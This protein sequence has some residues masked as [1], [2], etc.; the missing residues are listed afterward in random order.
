M[1]NARQLAVHALLRIQHDGAYANILTNELLKESNFESQDS[2]F[3]TDLVNGTTR[4][5]RYLDYVISCCVNRSLSEVQ[6]EVLAILQISTYSYLFRRQPEH[7]VVNEAVE[8]ARLLMGERAVGFVNGVMRKVVKTSQE[9]WNRATLNQADPDQALAIRYSMPDWIYLYFK[10][11]IS[12][13]TE[14]L[15]L[16]KTLNQAPEVSFL[17]PP[18]SKIELRDA[19]LGDWSPFAF[20]PSSKGNIRN[21]LNKSNFIV[22]DEGSQLIALASLLVPIDGP[23]KRWLDMTAGPGGK[24]TFLAAAARSRKATLVAN[25]LHQHRANLIKNNLDRLNLSAEIVVSDALKST[26]R[27]EFDRVLLDAPCTGLGALRRRAESR[28]RKQPQDL[29]QL[30]DLQKQL[31]NRAIAATRPGGIVAYTTCSLHP[32]ET[33]EVVEFALKTSNVE[34]ID[35][36]NLL[37]G[38]PLSSSPYIKLWPHRHGTDGMFMAALKVG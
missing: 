17:R 29:V 32:R 12:D 31:L 2:A 30:V 5:L 33:S 37:P 18:G 10:K 35:I 15:R 7:A 11:Q 4:N 3:F 14:L 13:T 26:W 6:S 22:Q 27:A 28:W 19:D 20:K 24:A 16:L 9:D 25:E 38:V 36:G 8:L 23:D 34:T 21:Q 1:K